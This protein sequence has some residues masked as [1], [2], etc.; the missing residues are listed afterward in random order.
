M[1]GIRLSRIQD[2]PLSAVLFVHREDANAS[3]PSSPEVQ[4][5]GGKERL[6]ELKSPASRTSQARI[7]VWFHQRATSLQILHLPWCA[8]HQLAK[9]L[10]VANCLGRSQRF[11]ILRDQP[12]LQD[13]YL[14]QIGAD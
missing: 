1:A 9:V 7:P 3:F 12:S 13:L 6:I 8:F 11:R 14:A 2:K 10:E 4:K 5:V